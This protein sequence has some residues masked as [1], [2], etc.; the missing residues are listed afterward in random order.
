MALLCCFCAAWTQLCPFLWYSYCTPRIRPPLRRR[1]A[2]PTTCNCCWAPFTKGYTGTASHGQAASG[3]TSL[4]S[5]DSFSPLPI[6][7]SHRRRGLALGR[8]FRFPAGQQTDQIKSLRTSRYRKE[9]IGQQAARKLKCKLLWRCLPGP[10]MHS[11]RNR[12]TPPVRAALR[13]LSSS[14]AGFAHFFSLLRCTERVFLGGSSAG[15][16]AAEIADRP[17][18]W[19]NSA[20]AEW[21]ALLLFSP[22][23][24][25]LPTPP[26]ADKVQ[27]SSN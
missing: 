3:C 6:E 18:K 16:A 19:P 1:A 2:I 10:A 25:F 4:C 23:D 24:L 14:T 12:L 5:S 13:T 27:S 15:F 22:P 9:E 20:L 26:I 11:R 21:S 7:D 17:S 8:C